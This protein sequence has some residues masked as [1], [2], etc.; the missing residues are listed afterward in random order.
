MK[1][2]VLDHISGGLG[3]ANIHRRA[4]ERKKDHPV[5]EPDDREGEGE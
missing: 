3:G 1:K 5:G 4:S 2:Y